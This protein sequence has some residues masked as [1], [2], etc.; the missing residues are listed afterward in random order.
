M[1]QEYIIAHA[2]KTVLRISGLKIHGMDTRQV[3]ELLEKK[4]HTFVR[5][6]GVTGEHVE[7]DVYNLPPEQIAQDEQGVIHTVALAEGI[8]A[9]DL[10][11]ITCNK[12]IVDVAYDQIPDRPISDCPRERWMKVR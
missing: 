2:D 9:T 12:K 10:A 1:E 8:T 3:E 5:V 7:M 11:K 4:L 6:I